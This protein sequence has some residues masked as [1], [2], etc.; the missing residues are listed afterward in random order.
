VQYGEFTSSDGRARRFP[1]VRLAS[2]IRG[3]T[4][5]VKG[6]GRRRI[7]VIGMFERYHEATDDSAPNIAAPRARLNALRVTFTS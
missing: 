7:V 3:L 2:D 5:V 4:E 1:T 6:L